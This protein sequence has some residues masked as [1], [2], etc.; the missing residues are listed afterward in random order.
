MM[1]EREKRDFIAKEITKRIIGPGYAEGVFLCNEEA[2]DEILEDRPVMVYTGGVLYPKED[3]NLDEIEDAV[4][5]ENIDVEAADNTVEDVDDDNEDT[6]ESRNSKSDNQLN[7]GIADRADFKPSHIGLV[8][9]VADGTQTVDIDVRYG[10]YHVL[11]DSEK[12]DDNLVCEHVKVK[13]G[14]CSLEQLKKTFAYYDSCKSLKNEL[15]SY[16]ADCMKDL[17]LIDED[18]LT[19]SP[20]RIFT[21]EDANGKQKFLKASAF[22]ELPRNKVASILLELFNN[23]TKAVDMPINMSRESV[24]SEIVTI[25]NLDLFKPILD[26]NDWSNISDNITIDD[27]HNTIRITNGIFKKIADINLYDILY[28]D[29]PVKNHLLPRL[30]QFWYFKREQKTLKRY[31]LPITERTGC[32]LLQDSDGSLQIRWKVMER[33]DQK[34]LRRKYVK[35]L[36]ENIKKR[37]KKQQFEDYIHQAELKMSSPNIISYSEPHRSSIADD[38]YDVNEALYSDIEVYAKGVNCGVEWN[39][40]GDVKEVM[41]TYSPSQFAVSFNPESEFEEVRTA[42]DVFDLTI[43]STVDKE[44]VLKRFDAIA[45]K[46]KTW[47]EGQKKLANG[48]QT[49]DGILKEQ[50]DFYNR[51]VDNI[52][53]LRRHDKAYKCFQLAN[54]AMYIQMLVSRDSYFKKDRDFNIIPEGDSFDNDTLWARF[55][56]GKIRPKYRPFQLAFLLMNVKSTFENNDTFRDNNVDLIWFPT[57]GGKTEAYL[58]L[59]ALT[60]ARR[61]LE[62]PGDDGDGISVIMRYTLRLLTAQQFERASFLICALEFLRKNLEKRQEY[63]EMYS[64]GTTPIILGMWIGSSSTPNKYTDLNRGKYDNFHQY[65][66]GDNTK[67]T[68]NPFPI[69]Y[70]PWCGCKLIKPAVQGNGYVHGY[71]NLY[72]GNGETVR[73]INDNCIFCDGLPIMFIDEQLYNNPPTLLFATVDKFAQ[74]KDRR[75]GEMFGCNANRSKPDLIIQDELH[76]ISGPL[77]S[78]VGMFETMI[79]EACTERNENGEIIKKPKIITSTATTRNTQNLIKQLYNR[80]VRSFP[81]SGI[82]YSNNFFSEAVGLNDCKRRYVGFAPTG[83]SAS[84]LEIRTI[85]AQVV[86]KEKLIIAEL[87]SAGID[88]LDFDRVASFLVDDNNNLREDIDNYWSLVLYYTNLKSLGRA[89]SR[90][91]QEIKSNAESMRAYLDEYPALNFICENFHLRTEEFTSRQE[92]SRIKELLVVAANQ[93]NI[94]RNYNSKMRVSSKMD[95]VQATNMISVGID[96]ARWNTMIV[97][98]QPL[99]TADYIQSSSRVGRTYDGLVVNLYNPLNAREL[100]LYENYVPY[101]TAFYKFVEPLMVTTFTEQ[102]IDKLANNI[103]L[104]YMGAIKGYTNANQIKAEDEKNLLTMLKERSQSIFNGRDTTSLFNHIEVKINNIISILNQNQNYTLYNLFENNQTRIRDLEL[105]SSLR[106]VE[107]NTYIYYNEN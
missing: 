38:E 70:C 34:G 11:N 58:A 23:P 40:N 96:I 75:I 49:F 10:I 55:K 43:W 93:T 99:A 33:T 107:S 98:G 64:L 74:V 78:L 1:T 41:T 85:A 28:V 52:N 25:Q 19:I 4:E 17:F 44:D 20:R 50:E 94:E 56:E 29:D 39:V 89:C 69:S 71:D 30:L 68:N 42:C 57:G 91:G 76:L 7:L 73:C 62:Y 9:C 90:M 35:V 97:V 8:A 106:D 101:H 87:K 67:H 3:K 102:T 32:H 48:N 5:V 16:G 82:K 83:H 92:S 47:N 103:F 37:L 31:Q 26:E 18:N 105:M 6:N 77:G 12:K 21:F 61:R 63:K 86:A 100:S 53:Y 88:I 66:D 81:V 46:Y 14:Y 15:Y 59:T 84:E 72:D 95:I 27:E 22:P 45:S 54:T 80:N 65:L 51:L 104:C 60:I 36:L 13:L 2:T 24:L 79:E